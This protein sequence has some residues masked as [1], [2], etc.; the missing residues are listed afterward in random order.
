MDSPISIE[1]IRTL[2]GDGGEK[3]D[4]REQGCLRT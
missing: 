1:V 2:T 3:R 4:E